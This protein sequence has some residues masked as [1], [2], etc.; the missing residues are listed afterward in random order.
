MNGKLQNTASKTTEE[1]I[2]AKGTEGLWRAMTERAED[3]HLVTTK[4]HYSLPG[5]SE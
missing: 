1:Q 5:E 3:H 4:K 2:Q